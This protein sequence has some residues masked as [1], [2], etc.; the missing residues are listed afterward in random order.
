MSEVH[1]EEASKQG[2]SGGYTQVDTND[3]RLR[4]EY[5]LK[6]DAICL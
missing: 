1:T 4:I 2:N 6:T 3:I 5:Y